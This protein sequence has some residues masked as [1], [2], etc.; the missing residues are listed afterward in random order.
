MAD[1]FKE[2]KRKG[3]LPKLKYLKDN[4]QKLLEDVG[5]KISG[6]ISIYFKLYT[7]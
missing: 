6:L 7:K 1:Y 5:G 2:A 3:V 4:S